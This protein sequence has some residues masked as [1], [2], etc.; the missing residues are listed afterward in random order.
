M[1]SGLLG[2]GEAR[3]GIAG[4]RVIGDRLRYGVGAVE[5]LD[6]LDW[7]DGSTTSGA[8]PNCRYAE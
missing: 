6:V 2:G 4:G 1:E 7:L 3:N 5:A 8:A